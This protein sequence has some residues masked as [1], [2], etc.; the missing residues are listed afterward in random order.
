MSMEELK[1]EMDATGARSGQLVPKTQAYTFHQ[2]IWK[3]FSDYI[4]IGEYDYIVNLKPRL[5][6]R[7][8]KPVFFFNA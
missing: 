6:Q 3:K 4:E 1:S 8:V 5:R 2:N 7:T